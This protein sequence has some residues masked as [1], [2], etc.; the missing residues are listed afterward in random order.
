MTAYRMKG[1]SGQKMPAPSAT[2]LIFSARKCI[3]DTR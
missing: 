3:S 2:D 1:R